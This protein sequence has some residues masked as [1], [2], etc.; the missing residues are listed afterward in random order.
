VSRRVCVGLVLILSLA[1]RR[2]PV[3]KMF[4]EEMNEPASLWKTI[5]R[6]SKAEKEVKR[7]RWKKRPKQ[8]AIH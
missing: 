2:A 3:T 4:I 1:S 6:I 7:K 8:T 5:S